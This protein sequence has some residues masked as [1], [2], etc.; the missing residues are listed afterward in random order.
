MF[1][2]CEINVMYTEREIRTV[3]IATTII[4]KTVVGIAK[5]LNGW[6][7]YLGSLQT[8]DIN[9]TGK[10]GVCPNSVRETQS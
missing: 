7:H 6:L 1:S 3:T 5:T 4:I 9:L 8:V 10:V 2:Y